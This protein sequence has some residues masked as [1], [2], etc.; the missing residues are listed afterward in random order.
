MKNFTAKKLY[1]LA[2]GLFLGLCIWKFGNPVILDHKI[3]APVTPAEVL[4]E[5]WP[6]HWANWI[7][8]PLV[9]LGALLIFQEKISWSQSKW[10]WLLPL[11]WLGWQFVSATQTVDTDLTH[12]TLWQ[13]S[14]CVAC[15]F[16][17]ALIFARDN[18]WRWLLPG[19]L[20]AFA[21]C[22]VRGIDQHVFEFP[23][24]HQMLVE[25][26]SAGWTNFPPEAVAQMR[27]DNIIILT[28][29]AE[30]V[31]PVMLDKFKK[32][33][34]AGTLV[35]PNALAGI[36]LLL[37]PLSLALAFGATKNLKPP[38]RLAAIGLTIFL[39][40]AAFFWSGSKLGWLIGIAIAGLY[41]LRLDWPKKIKLTAIALVLIGGLGVFAVRFHHYFSAGATSVGARFD[42]WR[43]AIQTAAAK[44]VFGSGSGTF[45]RP[46]AQ[47]K[48]PESEMARLAHN[49]YLEQFSDSG[50]IGGLAYAAWIF[51]ALAA[52][53]KKLW[54][55]NS[56]LCRRLGGE[57]QIKSGTPKAESRNELEIPYIVSY[58]ED[59]IPFAILAGLLGW[60]AQGFGEF[61]LF[62]PALAWTAFM[63]L[64]CMVG[65]DESG[66]PCRQPRAQHDDLHQKLNVSLRA[67]VSGVKA[68]VTE[69]G[70]NSPLYKAMGYVPTSERASGLTRKTTNT[71]TI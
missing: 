21:F 38:I 56:Q 40:G 53:D 52:A 68:N 50:L 37:W 5:P 8:L 24:N 48:S 66:W 25:G 46:Y 59:K 41:L 18:L 57:A 19:L 9:C 54:Q 60:F 55:K 3:T 51:L 4:N 43:A 17:G 49:D 22:L 10:L 12:A 31:N 16:W 69:C 58:Y 13:F 47:I 27:S 28:N 11:V 20:A 44:P 42:Y 36:I 14:G 33:R 71:A 61:G 39:G 1:A 70:P 30:T 2:F 63:L 67:V 32:G 65:L 62:I 15:Y 45:Q 34:V 26:E 35:Y 7:L 64:G 29:G 6:L 23:Q